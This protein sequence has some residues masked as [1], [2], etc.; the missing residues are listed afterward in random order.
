MQTRAQASA[1]VASDPIGR[2]PPKHTAGPLSVAIVCPAKTDVTVAATHHLPESS[3]PWDAT[4]TP[5]L[6][7]PTIP[8]S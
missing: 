3:E 1:G 6:R 8:R 7:P 5:S 2:L 4:R